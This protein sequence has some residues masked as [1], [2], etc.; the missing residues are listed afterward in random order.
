VVVGA[1]GVPLALGGLLISTRGNSISTIK[2]GCTSGLVRSNP[3]KPKMV[4]S[5]K[6]MCSR[7]EHTMAMV[8]GRLYVAILFRL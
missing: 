7:I 8:K 5:S 1:S 3:G 2:L 4:P 6:A